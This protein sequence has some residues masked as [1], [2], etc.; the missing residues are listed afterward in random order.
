MRFA[1]LNRSLVA[2]RH[3]LLL[4]LALRAA[5]RRG[6]LAGQNPLC[7]L[8]LAVGVG[9]GRNLLR[10]SVVQGALGLPQQL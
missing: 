10:V 2:P 5:R 7:F 1:I 6:E 9:L 8:L 4:R 3:L